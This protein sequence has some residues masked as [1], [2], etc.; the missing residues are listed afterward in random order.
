M[1]F[2]R[3]QVHVNILE[4]NSHH[5]KGQIEPNRPQI[6]R[7]TSF[8]LELPFLALFVPEN[9]RVVLL[10]LLA[11]FGVVLV[12]LPPSPRSF[13]GGT[14]WPPTSFGGAAFLSPFVGWCCYRILIMLGGGV[15][16]S[17][18][19]SGAAWWLP[20]PLGKCW[21]LSS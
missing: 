6:G 15:S 18:L 7:S 11:P 1:I 19:V 16:S 12:S 2:S 4:N 9:M 20:S 5:N 21:L 13:L 14:G 17:A 10:S 3:E 8:S